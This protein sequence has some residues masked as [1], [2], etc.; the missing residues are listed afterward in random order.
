MV[1]KQCSNREWMIGR[2]RGAK[3][4]QTIQPGAE[5]ILV[6]ALGSLILF[7][8]AARCSAAIGKGGKQFQFDIIIPTASGA[9]FAMYIKREKTG[10]VAQTGTKPIKMNIQKAHHM[11]G[12]S[13]KE[14][15][16]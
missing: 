14:S 1:K 15:T 9:I 7:Q 2:N 11:L 6:F 5:S 16:R 12:H 8:L 4:C 13:N 3:N 10:E